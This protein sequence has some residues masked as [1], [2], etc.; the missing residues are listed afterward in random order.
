MYALDWSLVLL[1]ARSSGARLA[2]RRLGKTGRTADLA[3]M[4]DEETEAG[5]R[6]G[7]HNSGN[8]DFEDLTKFF[9]LGSVGFVDVG[10]RA[11]LHQVDLKR[12]RR[13]SSFRDDGNRGATI[14][15]N[16]R[17]SLRSGCNI[18]MF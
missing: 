6:S 12:S 15:A 13:C 18:A 9:L 7:R 5:M 2:Q 4:Q 17:N 3:V 8:K 14:S 1:A 16:K 11:I 10:P